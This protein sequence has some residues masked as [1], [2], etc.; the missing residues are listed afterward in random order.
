[1]PTT[2]KVM[3][4]AAS[5][6]AFPTPEHVEPGRPALVEQL[7][8]RS[9]TQIQPEPDPRVAAH[10]TR[11]QRA[12]SRAGLS[13]AAPEDFH[14]F[15]NSNIG[16]ASGN[17]SVFNEEWKLLGPEVAADRVRESV[18]YLL[19]GTEPPEL[20]DRFTR[21]LDPESGLGMKGWKQA[22]LTKTLCIVYPAQWLPIV[23]YDSGDVGKR[24]L[25]RR[26]WGLE[27]PA[28]DRT[29]MTIGR[30]I[31]WSNDLLLQ[32]AGDGFAHAEHAASFL[33]WAKDLAD[34]QS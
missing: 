30:L 34:S 5:R 25:A 20:E 15:A 8:K 13:G 14:Y 26:I 18:G 1:M 10:W 17:M 16:A 12:F 3:A 19:Y 23:T 24:S 7:K 2:G 27:L 28:A 6:D 21:L 4:Y 32:L 29:S 22:L 11:Y 33:W 9:L 31:G